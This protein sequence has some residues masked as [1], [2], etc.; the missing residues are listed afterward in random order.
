MRFAVCTANFGSWADPG[1]AVRAAKAAEGAGW[2]GYF[3]WDHLAFVWGPP[4]GDA[5]TILGA[6]ATATEGLTVGSAVTPVPRRRPQV[7]AQIVSTVA[8]LND[9]RVVF[10]A[11]LGGNRKEFEAFGESY[12]P[13]RRLALLDE[14]LALISDLWGDDPI[15]VW[16]GGNSPALLERA[17]RHDGWIADSVRPDGMKMSP[18]EVRERAVKGEVA[19]NG[20]SQPDE[21]ELV[22]SYE[23][24]GATW[25]LENLH[26]MRGT[27]DDLLA[28]IEQ[29][30]PSR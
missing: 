30:P 14:G 7:L 28:R 16:V 23:A 18:E 19:V 5:W 3:V 29:G 8:S 17:A 27:P 2:D 11:G 21:G 26:D 13:E 4:S 6:V 25:W 12:D 9:G 24:A 15:P 10:G 20:Y 22:R 1:L